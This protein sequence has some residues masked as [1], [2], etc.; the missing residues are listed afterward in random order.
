MKDEAG[1][2]EDLRKSLELQ[3][4]KSTSAEGEFTS[5]ENKMAER[6]R[7]MNPYGF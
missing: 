4:E 6:Y 5:V 1:A 7:D 2:A 3:P